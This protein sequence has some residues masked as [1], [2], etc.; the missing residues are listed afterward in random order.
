MD[1]SVNSQFEGLTDPTIKKYIQLSEQ[2]QNLLRQVGAK[3]EAI[4]EYCKTVIDFIN[5]YE[6]S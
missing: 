2:M 1:N 3:M 4:S 6:E 5:K